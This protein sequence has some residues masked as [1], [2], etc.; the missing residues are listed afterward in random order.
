MGWL[1]KLLG[2]DRIVPTHIDTMATFREED[3]TAGKAVTD[4]VRLRQL[5]SQASGGAEQSE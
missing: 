2:S 3:V 4:A 5:V 1:N